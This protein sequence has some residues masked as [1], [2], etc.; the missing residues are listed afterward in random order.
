MNNIHLTILGS[1]YFLNIL[2][3]LEFK[4]LLNF[5]NQFNSSDKKI[6]VKILF[7]ENLKIQEVRSYLLKNEPLILDFVDSF[8]IFKGQHF[9]RKKFYKTQEFKI[10]NL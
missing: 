3:E 5:S 7:P 9:K 6:F 2:N 10:K 1:S 8:S 4:N